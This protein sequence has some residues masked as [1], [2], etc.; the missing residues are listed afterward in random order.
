MKTLLKINMEN[1]IMAVVV[2]NSD[3]L[4]FNGCN[5]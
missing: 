3:A 4:T 1:Y 5:V 2:N